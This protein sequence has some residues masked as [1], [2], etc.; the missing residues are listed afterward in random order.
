VEYWLRSFVP[1]LALILL[2]V[3]VGGDVV[4]DPAHVVFIISKSSYNTKP[5]VIG[6]GCMAWKWIRI[7]LE[8]WM[9]S[10]YK[11]KIVQASV[12]NCMCQCL[13]FLVLNVLIPAYLGSRGKPFFQNFKVFL[14]CLPFVD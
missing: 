9:V 3:A 10:W 14:L 13:K 1:W 4:Q 12:S 2:D 8:S 5:T 7:S 11:N 6:V